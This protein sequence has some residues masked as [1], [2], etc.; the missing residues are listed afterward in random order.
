LE[1]RSRGAADV[2]LVDNNEK[3]IRAC[4]QNITTLGL[5]GVVAIRQSAEHFLANCSDSFDIGFAEPPYAEPNP[6]VE[7]LVQAILPRLTGEGVVAIERSSRGP[8]FPW[9]VG[10]EAL[11]QRSY[12]E[13]IVYYA[14][15]SP[16]G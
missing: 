6:E 4:K 16:A 12:G 11:R 3:A 2:I 5:D 9:P 14:R 1:S 10:Y 13:A 7:S 8:G 15:L